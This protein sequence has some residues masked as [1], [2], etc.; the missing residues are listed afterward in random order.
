MQ[1]FLSPQAPQEADSS[2]QAAETCGPESGDSRHTSHKAASK[3]GHD[4]HATFFTHEGLHS[5]THGASESSSH[6]SAVFSSDFH[7]CGA[8]V[9]G[10]VLGGWCFWALQGR[11]SEGMNVD[12]GSRLCCSPMWSEGQSPRRLAARVCWIA[13]LVKERVAISYAILYWKCKHSAQMQKG[14]KGPGRGWCFVV[15]C[16]S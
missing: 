6:G 1:S 15:E 12:E 13:F 4:Q 16:F 8:A 3:Q 14:A 9:G 5:K 2:P 7:D 10:S 11:G